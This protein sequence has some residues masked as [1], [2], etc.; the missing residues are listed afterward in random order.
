M[1]EITAYKPLDTNAK[2]FTRMLS[3]FRFFLSEERFN[4]GKN[5]L[6]TTEN[7]RNVG[8]LLLP[9]V[10]DVRPSRY[11]KDARVYSLPI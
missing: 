3:L 4:S 8:V 1:E 5:N 10:I 7:E 6:M 2:Q 11:T 9:R